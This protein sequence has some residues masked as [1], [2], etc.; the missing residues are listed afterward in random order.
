M[1]YHLE[2]LPEFEKLPEFRQDQIHSELAGAPELMAFLC[3][4]MDSRTE[5]LDK[6]MKHQSNYHLEQFAVYMADCM[7][8]KR[9]IEQLKSYF[10]T[11]TEEEENE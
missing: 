6:A 2:M 4:F 3:E 10:I 9:E 7:G 8:A 11:L 5:Q 1:K